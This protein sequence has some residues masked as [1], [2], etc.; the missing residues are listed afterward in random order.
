M[1]NFELYNST[2]IIFGTDSMDKIADQIRPFGGKVLVTYGEGSIKTNGI[3]TKV[4]DQLKEFDVREFGGIEPNP[5]VETIRKI[6]EQYKEFE[7]D[8]VLAVGGG[9]V[10]DGTKLFISS[11]YYD[12]DPWDF[13]VKEG[14]QPKKYLPLG[15]VLTLSATGTE[16][17]GNA[18]ITNWEK[19]EKLALIKKELHP[20][21]SILDPRNTFSVSR[22]QTIYG[23]VDAFSHVFEQYINTEENAPIQDR[24]SEGILMT[25]IENSKKVLAEPKNYEA[26]ANIMLSACVALNGLIGSGVNQ[27]WATHDMEH[28]LSAFY[29]IPHAAGLAIITPRWM[30]VVKDQKSKK[31]IQY[32][33]RIWSLK[34]NEEEILNK[35]IEKTYDFFKSLGAKMNLTEWNIDKENFPVIIQR[36]TKSKIGEF[37]LTALQIEE[38]L[39]NCLI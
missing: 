11:M 5:R 37:P 30:K 31:I 15:T 32:G 18:V 2:K 20:V 29:D 13:L 28:E 4:M 22:D 16:M 6:I 7:P 35:A 12:G 33:K 23:I 34:G 24:F 36:L 8:F 14:V 10:I 17:N 3:Y 38:I 26:R 27:D 25:L 21:F 19:H 1:N 9:S 39:S